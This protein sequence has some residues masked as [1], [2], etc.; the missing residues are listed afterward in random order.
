MAVN[1]RY[2]MVGIPLQLLVGMNDNLSTA[3]A[4]YLEDAVNRYAKE[5][6][7]FQRVDHIQ[8]ARKQGCLGI[9]LGSKSLYSTYAVITFRRAV[10]PATAQGAGKLAAKE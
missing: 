8:V 9:W 7:E 2:K 4:K 6:W 3:A 5:G 1:Y 10:A